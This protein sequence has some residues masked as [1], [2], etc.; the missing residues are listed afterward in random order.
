MVAVVSP[1][2]VGA[3]LSDVKRLCALALHTDSECK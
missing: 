2:R 1:A 3:A